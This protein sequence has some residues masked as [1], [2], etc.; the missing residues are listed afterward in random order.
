MG[1]AGSEGCKKMNADTCKDF[2][3]AL[4][5]YHDKKLSSVAKDAY[6]SEFKDYGDERMLLALEASYKKF[7]PGRIP[8]INDIKALLTEIR[9]TAWTKEKNKEMTDRH[10]LSRPRPKSQMG[11]ES[12]Q[13]LNRL[14]APFGNPEK[15]SG[16]QYAEEMLKMEEKYPGIGWRQ[17]ANQLREWLNKKE[18]RRQKEDLVM[19]QD[20]Q[21]KED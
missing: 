15:L 9:E 1:A 12:F 4:E 21:K 10:P 11:R 13:L 20:S 6:W 7:S 16:R 14:F 2:I 19:K 8:S 18:E 17:G 5:L 3:K